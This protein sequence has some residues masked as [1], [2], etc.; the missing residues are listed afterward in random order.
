MRRCG[1]QA[2]EHCRAKALQGWDKSPAFA[3]DADSEIGESRGEEKNIRDEANVSWEKE[4]NLAAEV[5]KI[6]AEVDRLMVK[7]GLWAGRPHRAANGQW[8]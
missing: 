3:A 6:K 7:S 2:F 4:L 1:P 5:L 8:A